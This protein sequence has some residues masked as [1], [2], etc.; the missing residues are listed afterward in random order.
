VDSDD[1]IVSNV[2]TGAD[3][4]V[5]KDLDSGNTVSQIG[6][7]VYCDLKVDRVGV[8]LELD[9]GAARH[10]RARRHTRRERATD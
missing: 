7:R 6:R 3:L 1:S 10:L 9:A 2:R 5:Y 8:R 4:A